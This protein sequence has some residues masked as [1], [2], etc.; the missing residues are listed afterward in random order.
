MDH[1][2]LNPKL[3]AVRSLKQYEDE[4]D[5]MENILHTIVYDYWEYGRR[6]NNFSPEQNKLSYYEKHQDTIFTKMMLEIS[7]NIDNFPEFKYYVENLVLPDQKLFYQEDFDDNPEDF[8]ESHGFKT[9]EEAQQ[10]IDKLNIN[11]FDFTNSIVF[12]GINEFANAATEPLLVELFEKFIFPLWFQIWEPQGIVDTRNNVQEVYDN[13]KASSP[14]VFGNLFA[15]TN[16]ALNTAH[17]TGSML[18][19]VENLT[20]SD[21]LKVVLK[22]LTDGE[23]N[24]QWDNELNEHGFYQSTKQTN[25][26][27]QQ[28]G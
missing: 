19:H 26:K 1:A 5:N 18:D 21:N 23:Y 28:L 3:W 24:E 6:L 15:R 22:G 11:N 8:K 13:L 4:E 17:Q 10:F 20:G 7:R 9:D 27:I 25:P 12:Q 16:I 2:I 14:D